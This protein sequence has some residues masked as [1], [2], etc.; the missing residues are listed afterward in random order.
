MMEDNMFGIIELPRECF[1]YEGLTDV[2]HGR[3]RSWS[4]NKYEGALFAENTIKTKPCEL[5]KITRWLINKN[6]KR[7]SVDK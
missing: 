3:Q 7:L 1:R 4:S 2:G 5:D 6:K